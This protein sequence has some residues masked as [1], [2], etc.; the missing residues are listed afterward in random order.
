MCLCLYFFCSCVEV[1]AHVI[2]CAWG[3]VRI[4]DHSALSGHSLCAWGFVRIQNDHS[5]HYHDFNSV[6][7]Q[8]AATVMPMIEQVHICTRMY[9]RT[10]ERTRTAPLPS[11]NTCTLYRMLSQTHTHTHRSDACICACVCRRVLGQ[12]TLRRRL[13]LQLHHH[14]GVCG[15]PPK[16]AD[17][18][19]K[20]LTTG[21]S[22]HRKGCIDLKAPLVKAD[23]WS[24]QP[25]CT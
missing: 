11:L 4:H 10:Y 3:F 16:E 20:R 17:H 23:H 14:Q 2:L 15:A 6:D 21:Q 12:E 1:R 22:S 7:L 25:C 24:R 9:A 18:W 13:P 5:G 8:S 19:S